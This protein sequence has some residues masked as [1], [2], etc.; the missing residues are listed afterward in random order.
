MGAGQSQPLSIGYRP[1]NGVGFLRRRDGRQHPVL[2][3][4]E[5]VLG[6]PTGLCLVDAFVQDLVDAGTDFGRCEVIESEVVLGVDRFPQLL[7]F[8]VAILADSDS[9]FLF[10]GDNFSGLELAFCELRIKLKERL[11]L[12]VD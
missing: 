9:G 7:E 3:G 1:V 10:V 8:G 12:A 4:R 5:Q 11:G 6:E 2:A